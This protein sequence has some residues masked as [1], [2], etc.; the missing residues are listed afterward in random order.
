[1][2]RVTRDERVETACE[3]YAEATGYYVP[4]H[5]GLSSESADRMRKGMRAA[6]D[7]LDA[8]PAQEVGYVEPIEPGEPTYAD[9]SIPA[10][11]AIIKLTN[12][13][14][15]ALE[16]LYSHPGDYA[17]FRD[18]CKMVRDAEHAAIVAMTPVSSGE[19]PADVIDHC[20]KICDQ[21]AINADRRAADHLA[22][23]NE[24]AAVAAHEAALNKAE[25]AR[26][27]AY[28]IRDRAARRYQEASEAAPF[29]CRCPLELR[30]A[31]FDPRCS[32]SAR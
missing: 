26:D 15:G 30:E 5:R 2:T 13:A 16:Y 6:L 4:F 18:A 11:V 24:A 20:A 28:A 23:G 31:C 32:K 9:P 12:A 25:G 14:Y 19:Q 8:I 21:V 22:S 10:H 29:Q 1:M 3:A 7:A 27:C 17:E